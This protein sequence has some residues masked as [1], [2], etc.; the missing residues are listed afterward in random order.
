MEA[1]NEL[2]DLAPEDETEPVD[3]PT[4]IE[5]KPP[6]KEEVKPPIE[7]EKKP[8]EVKPEPQRRDDRVPLATFLQEKRKMTEALESERAERAKLRQELD[9]LKNPPKPAPQYDVDPK[10]FI[11]HATKAAAQDV[12]AKLEETKAGVEEVKKHSQQT[13]E[14]QQAQ[15]FF[16]DLGA[17]ENEFLAQTPDY[18]NALNFV[19]QRVYQQT[20]EFN[21]DMT[22]EAIV[23]SIRRQELAMAAQMMRA[24]RNPHEAAYRLAM[25]NGYVKAA[26]PQDG[27]E[28]ADGTT[29]LKLKEEKKLDPAKTLGASGGAAGDDQEDTDDDPLQLDQAM[30]EIFGGRKR[31]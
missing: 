5:A 17:T 26:P 8:E 16:D 11:E 24:G 23:E 4:E 3:K 25:I 31:A 20:L 18:Y 10:G 15:R 9:A 6:A 28:T 21:P 19:R 30:K 12:I 27:K 14:E 1:E 7:A 13:A 22:H 29:E 2:I